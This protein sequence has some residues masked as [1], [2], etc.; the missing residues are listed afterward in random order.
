ML[1]RLLEAV[2]KKNNSYYKS[3]CIDLVNCLLKDSKVIVQYFYF[4]S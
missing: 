3:V 2:Y 4:D 1:K